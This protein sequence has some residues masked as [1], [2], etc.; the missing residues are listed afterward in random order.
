MSGAGQVFH[1]QKQRQARLQQA[2]NVPV[3]K[4]FF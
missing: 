3:Q 2:E 1:G 4:S